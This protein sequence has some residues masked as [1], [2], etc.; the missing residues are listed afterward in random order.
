MTQIQAFTLRFSGRA[1]RI[2]T[3][4]RV[5]DDFDPENPPAEEPSLTDTKA[6]WDTGAT[7]S[8]I[9][10]DLANQLGLKATGKATVNHAGGQGNCLTYVVNLYLP[11]SVAIAGVQVMS[12]PSLPGF[13]VIIGM[14]IICHGDLSITNE[15]GETM[16]SFRTPSIKAI[17]YVESANRLLYRNV[18]RNDQ[19]P[20]GSG[21]KFKRCHP[22]KVT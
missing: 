9:S 13:E 15:G 18:G 20:C 8:V 7:G 3:D 11:N 17:D 14:N 21:K 12:S 6:L 5:S 19:C 1:D 22:K 2:I 4:V 16:V 10:Q